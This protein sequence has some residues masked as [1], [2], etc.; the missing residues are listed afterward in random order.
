MYQNLKQN[1]LSM[2]NM[3]SKYNV[4]AII[5]AG[6]AAVYFPVRVMAYNL[7]IITTS[8]VCL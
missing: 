3:L 2:V 7:P 6:F 4:C 5:S 1:C 8:V